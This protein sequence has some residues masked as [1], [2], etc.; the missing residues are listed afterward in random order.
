ME[1]KNNYKIT[2][3]LT[4]EEKELLESKKDSPEKLALK[5]KIM[6]KILI[7]EN[8]KNGNSRTAIWKSN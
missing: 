4:N 8:K 3:K 5:K 1:N 7:K 6:K 2:L